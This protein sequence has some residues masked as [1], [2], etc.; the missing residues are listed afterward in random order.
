VNPDKRPV[1]VSLIILHIFM[2]IPIGFHPVFRSSLKDLVS[3]YGMAYAGLSP[4]NILLMLLGILVIAYP[5]IALVLIIC[6]WLALR[7]HRFKAAIRMSCI[8]LL[9]GI[10]VGLLYYFFLE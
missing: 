2:V 3:D 4:V 8:G 1:F 9:M 7:R 10:P 5:I 6:S